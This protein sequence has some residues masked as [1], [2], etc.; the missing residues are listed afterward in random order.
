MSKLE[1][2]THSYADI[3][4]GSMAQ[5]QNKNQKSPTHEKP[6]PAIVHLR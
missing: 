6:V 4:Q 2:K 3:L 5:T 1:T